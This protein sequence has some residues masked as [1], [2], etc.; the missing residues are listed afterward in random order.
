MLKLPELSKVD[1]VHRLDVVPVQAEELKGV[2]QPLQ[3]GRGQHSEL[4]VFERPANRMAGIALILDSHAQ[5]LVLIPTA[6]GCWC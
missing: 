4:V 3:S 6:F 2:L 5:Q 1:L